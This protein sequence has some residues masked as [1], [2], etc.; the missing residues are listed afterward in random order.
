MPPKGVFAST[1]GP[2]ARNRPRRSGDLRA[3]WPASAVVQG[4]R[5]CPEPFVPGRPKR[6]L[7][8]HI[9]SYR[10]AIAIVSRRA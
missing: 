3:S 9:V 1:V 4:Q 8:G 2:Y 7:S 10:L 5:R 6:G